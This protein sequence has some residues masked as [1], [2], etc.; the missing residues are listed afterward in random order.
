[1]IGLFSKKKYEDITAKEVE[2]IANDQDK[3][4]LDVRELSEWNEG[5]IPSAKHIVLGTLD[6]RLHE[7]DK[8]KEIITVCA[9]GGRSARAAALLANKGYK[10]KNMSGGMQAWTGPRKK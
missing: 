6:V 2:K 7:I 9:S 5:H 1:M 4:I 3:I 8:D 10:V